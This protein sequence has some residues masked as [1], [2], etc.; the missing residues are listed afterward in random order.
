MNKNLADITI[1]VDRS[2]SMESCREDAEGGINE[3][4]RQ[5]KM[6][7]GHAIL[8]L[9]EFDDVAKYVFDAVPIETVTGRYTLVP[10]GGTALLDAIG[11]AVEKTGKRLA[12]M[13]EEDRPG[14][15]VVIIST[16]GHENGSRRYDNKQI[17]D[18]IARQESVYKWQFSYL[19]ANQNAFDVA[20]SIGIS[21]GSSSSFDVANAGAAYLSA[22]SN[23]LRMRSMSFKGEDVANA[24]TDEEVA[25]MGGTN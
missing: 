4:I 15:V 17:A 7:H 18:M 21:K 8:T 19:G 6:A 14:L 10:R 5:Q 16:D 25:A 20:Y 12:A 1:I 24:Y 23:V 2:G 11:G 3:F 13:P 9:I 22:S